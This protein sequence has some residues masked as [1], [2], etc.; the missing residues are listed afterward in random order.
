MSVP[1][2]D[3][4]HLLSEFLVVVHHDDFHGRLAL[5]FSGFDSAAPGPLISAPS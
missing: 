2:Q 5:H 3:I 1:G 4:R